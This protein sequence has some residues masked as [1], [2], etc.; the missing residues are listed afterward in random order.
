MLILQ[1]TIISITFDKLQVIQTKLFSY[2]IW[3]GQKIMIKMLKKQVIK[4]SHLEAN[5]FSIQDT[6]N[7]NII[8]LYIFIS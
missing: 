2:I 6:Q 1:I 3:D 4:Y 5:H 8:K 7:N